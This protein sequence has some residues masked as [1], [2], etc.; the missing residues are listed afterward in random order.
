M[1][2]WNDNLYTHEWELEGEAIC[3]RCE[4]PATRIF[5]FVCPSGFPSRDR[6]PEPYCDDHHPLNRSPYRGDSNDLWAKRF[7][8]EQEQ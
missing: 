4:K 8:T 6:E 3:R 1:F 7:I 2:L 5:R